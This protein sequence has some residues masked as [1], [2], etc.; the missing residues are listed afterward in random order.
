MFY[1][2][3]HGFVKGMWRSK[4][5]WIRFISLSKMFIRVWEPIRA[6]CLTHSISSDIIACECIYRLW[7]SWRHDSLLS[8][9]EKWIFRKEEEM[10]R[11]KDNK[12]TIAVKRKR[13]VKKST[14][15][16]ESWWNEAGDWRQE[17]EPLPEIAS[18]F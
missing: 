9:I 16:K 1:V 2:T 5:S 8:F 14:L 17:N 6:N 11:K 7:I 4:T 15:D 12:S 18:N 13:A 10:S 3:C